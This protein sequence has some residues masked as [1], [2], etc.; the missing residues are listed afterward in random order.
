MSPDWLA[1]DGTVIAALI[2]AAVAVVAGLLSLLAA[3]MTARRQTRAEQERA[4]FEARLQDSL[5]KG[6]SL[7]SERHIWAARFDRAI[8]DLTDP[9]LVVRAG[10][11]LILESAARRDE[12]GGVYSTPSE[13]AR[14]LAVLRTFR[15]RSGSSS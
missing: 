3:I 14:A 8:S 5:L 1:S 9:S 11:I 4:K 12:E 15:T 10:A 6:Q 13:R 2:A 7:A